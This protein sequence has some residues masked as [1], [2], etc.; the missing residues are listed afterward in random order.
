MDNTQ[1]LS[2][3]PSIDEALEFLGMSNMDKA[4]GIQALLRISEFEALPL[5][6]DQH[7]TCVPA[8]MKYG[9]QFDEY[10]KYVETRLVN[11]KDE[12]KF[13]SKHIPYFYLLSESKDNTLIFNIGGVIHDGIEY[14]ICE[15]N[16]RVAGY[17]SIGYEKFYFDREQ[18]INFKTE[19]S[20]RFSEG[21]EVKDS[22]SNKTGVLEQRIYAFK[23]WLVGNSGK[24]IHE[25]DDLQNCYKNLGEPT[26]DKVWEGL[27]QM[28]NR[29]FACGKADFKRAMA[30]VVRFTQGTGKGRNS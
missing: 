22:S 6:F 30:D 2:P 23:Y 18:L 12:R 14:N 5:F 24:S 4:M 27:Q 26:R 1:I 28:D 11:P 19:Y 21:Q 13:W 10:G 7:L 9:D 25:K 29:L 8:S 3:K 20:A 17:I 16:R 15:G